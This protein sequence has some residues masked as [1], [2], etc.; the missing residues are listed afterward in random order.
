MYLVMEGK[1][2]VI[3]SELE[4]FRKP[5]ERWKIPVVLPLIQEC[6]IFR[7]RLSPEPGITGPISHHSHHVW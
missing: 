5:V 2:V 7:F 6:F 3:G 1:V 4:P